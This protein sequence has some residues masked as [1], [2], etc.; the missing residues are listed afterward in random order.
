MY[1]MHATAPFSKRP[2]RRLLVHDTVRTILDM[3]VHAALPRL[4][5]VTNDMKLHKFSRL[6]G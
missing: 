6:R 1:S 3:H 2:D 4:L 5:W